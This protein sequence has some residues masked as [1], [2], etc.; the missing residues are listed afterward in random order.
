[1][2]FKTTSTGCASAPLQYDTMLGCVMSI[3]HTMYLLAISNQRSFKIGASVLMLSFRKRSNVNIFKSK[4]WIKTKH[5]LSVL[6]IFWPKAFVLF[7]F[8]NFFNY[9][10]VFFCLWKTLAQFVTFWFCFDIIF[11]KY[12]S[13][14][15]I[16]KQ[17]EANKNVPN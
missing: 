2:F 9:L 16:P 3:A 13:S 12:K 7:R 15:L 11:W 10:N 8:Q 17:L 14:V 1:M 4:F 5:F 6:K